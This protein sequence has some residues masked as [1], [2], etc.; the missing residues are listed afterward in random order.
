MQNILVVE[1]D[2][3]V[4]KYLKELLLDNSFSTTIASDGVE[5]LNS[6]KRLPPDLVL[7]DLGL[8]N[9]GGESVCLEIRKKYR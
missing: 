9:M 3:G 2:L 8:P 5:A 6:I 7:L 1:D 4:Q